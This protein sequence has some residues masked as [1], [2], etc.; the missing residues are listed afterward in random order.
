MSDTVAEQIAALMDDDWGIREDAA[1]ALGELNDARGVPPLIQAL[2]DSDRAVRQAAATS[3]TTLGEPAVVPLGF[4]LQ[5]PNLEVQEMASSILASIADDRVLEALSASL[6]SPNWI[7][8][9]HSAKALG[10]IQATDTLE[11]LI[12]LLQDKVPAVRDEAANAIQAMGEACLPSLLSQ[13]QDT[14][15]RVRL[16]AVEMLALLK[17][18]AAVE[19]LMAVVA[20]DA[21]TAVRQDA[22]RTLGKIGDSR[23]IPLFMEAL[24]QPSL[25]LPAIEAV[26]QIRSKEAVPA[27]IAMIDVLPIADFVDR[28]EGCTDPRYKVELPPLE[29]AVKSLAQIGDPQAIPV[30]LKALLSTLLRQE[31][32]EALTHFGNAGKEALF[33]QLKKDPDENLRHHIL[34]SLSR[35]GWRPGQIRL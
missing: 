30:L 8:R 20:N 18:S 16:R 29:A 9:M 2:R 27:L 19:P 11:T 22:V 6:L 35:L 25:K 23:A 1:T 26:G 24:T 3:L 34:E 15:W 13:L 17:S 10:R 32:A 28:M 31:A 4:C 12:L 33:A 7:V 14:N 21:D 5:D